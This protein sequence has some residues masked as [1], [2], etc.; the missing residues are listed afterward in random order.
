LG[1]NHDLSLF[2]YG[3]EEIASR[4]LAIARAESRVNQVC[5]RK[6]G[7]DGREDLT[8]ARHGVGD[9]ESP[10]PF[11]VTGKRESGAAL[12]LTAFRGRR[13]QSL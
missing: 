4:A 9:D 2:G 12:W 8:S 10:R 13:T 6:F 7:T 11:S 1:G 5:I 3:T